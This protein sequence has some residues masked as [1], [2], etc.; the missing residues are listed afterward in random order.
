MVDPSA[1]PEYQFPLPE[2]L[3][4]QEPALRRGDSRMLLVTPGM[5]VVGERPFRDIAEIL[6]PGDL[7][8]L[9]QSEV[10]PARLATRRTETGGAVEILLIQPEGPLSWT[11]MARPARRL[12]PGV[13][14]A[15]QGPDQARAPAMLTIER[16]NADGTV[17]V[18][19][20]VDPGELARQYGTMPLPPY[21][22][23]H[24]EQEAEGER[25]ALARDRY[26]T[27]YCRPDPRGAASVAAPTAGLHFSRDTLA[28]LEARGVNL[29]YLTLHVGPG[30]FQPPDREQ[31]A[32]R[33]LHSEFFHLPLA[34]SR[35]LA[36][37]RASGGRVIA[38][39][40][41]SLR[42]LETV[43]RLE[44]EAFDPAGAD[45][46]EFGPTALDPAPVFTGH[47]RRDGDHW[48]VSGQTRLFISPPDKVQAADGLLTNFHLPG[49]SLLMLVASLM[50]PET[51][52]GVYTHAVQ[53]RLRFY[54]YGDCMLILPPP[55]ENDE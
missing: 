38:V 50:G 8:V 27:V 13:E 28:R 1:N 48:E 45:T 54:S 10:L 51:W 20:A 14:L 53:E 29:A 36:E 39:G 7:L 2:A 26:Q 16:K 11:A 35:A 44:L 33:R 6:R 3:I 23:H 37:T 30:T 49:S 43:A 25:E 19:A 55:G 41:T 21:I 12:K 31:I 46:V 42:V 47:A 40:T 5:G 34:V 52:R 4:A 15:V 32:A 24:P 18:S 22:K 9:N 17:V